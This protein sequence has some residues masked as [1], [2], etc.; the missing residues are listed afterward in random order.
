[1]SDQKEEI[2]LKGFSTSHRQSATK[3]LE[4]VIEL[5]KQ[6][7]VLHPKPVSVRQIP[8][9]MTCPRATMVTQ[10]R[11]NEILGI[12]VEAEVAPE[13]STAELTPVAPVAV[14]AVVDKVQVTE[15]S[16]LVKIKLLNSK[17]DLLTFAEGVQIEVPEVNI[18]KGPKSIKQ[19]LI[20]KLSE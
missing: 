16:P 2:N 15:D 12:T 11:A 6:G 4:E 7:Y 10:Q 9:F 19:Y 17:A 5:T 3:F 1:M 20:N 18:K 8:T 13:G 14:A